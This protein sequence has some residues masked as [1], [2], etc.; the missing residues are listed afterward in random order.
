MK[1]PDYLRQLR[2]LMA[3]RADV[4]TTVGFH[5]EAAL[6]HLTRLRVLN[7]QGAQFSPKVEGACRRLIDAVQS[8]AL[9]LA[10]VRD[11]DVLLTYCASLDRGARP[12][13]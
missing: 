2:E 11:V 10:S 4:H 1:A 7:E 9:R 8:N 3:R 12:R 5:A 13:P 6:A